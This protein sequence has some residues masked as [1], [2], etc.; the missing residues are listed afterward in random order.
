MQA[1]REA[2]RTRFVVG[3]SSAPN[4]RT[5]STARM[6]R[7]LLVDQPWWEREDGRTLLVAQYNDMA[8]SPLG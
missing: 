6:L 3:P 4:S 8:H 2:G 1:T 5:R 7:R